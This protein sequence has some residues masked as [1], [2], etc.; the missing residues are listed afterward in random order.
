MTIDQVI[1][2]ALLAQSVPEENIQRGVLGEK[3]IQFAQS[4]DGLSILIPIPDKIHELRDQ[5]FVASSALAPGTP[6]SS[7]E[8]MRAEAPQISIYNGTADAALSSLTTSWLQ[9]NGAKVTDAGAADSAYLSTTV[10]DY[11]GNPFTIKYLV[12]SMGIS[13]YRIRRETVP[14]NPVDVELILGSDW[15]NQQ[16]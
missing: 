11:T 7:A 1:K 5:I 16:P 2:L 14:G 4:P 3:Y 15:K 8:Q 6:G 10:I 13:P 12:E 9:E